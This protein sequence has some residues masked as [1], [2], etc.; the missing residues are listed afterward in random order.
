MAAEISACAA[1]P[2]GAIL[3]QVRHCQWE[4]L[5]LAV[6]RAGYRQERRSLQA[7]LTRFLDGSP[8]CVAK[9]ALSLAAQLQVYLVPDRLC[10]MQRAALGAFIRCMC[11]SGQ[12]LQTI[13]KRHLTVLE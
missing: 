5:L 9:W 6:A 10:C 11:G 2:D 8:Q 1:M 13:P 3:A 4:L 12:S 7:V